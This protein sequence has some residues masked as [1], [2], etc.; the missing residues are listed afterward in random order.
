[1]KK[2]LFISSLAIAAMAFNI[3]DNK[4]YKCETVGI[5]FNDGNQTKNIPVTEKTKPLLEKTLNTFFKIEINKNKDI[6]NVKVGKVSESL[7][8]TGKWKDY[9][10]YENNVSSVIFMPDKNPESNNS[11]LIIPGERLVIYYNCK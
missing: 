9:D 1:M 10:R 3:V 7:K 5:S 8:F 2:F 6:V 4:N 11:A